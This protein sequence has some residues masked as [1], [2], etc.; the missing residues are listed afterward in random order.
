MFLQ[1]LF[2]CIKLMGHNI[3]GGSSTPVPWT[4]PA[5]NSP[6]LSSRLSRGTNSTGKTQQFWVSALCCCS[7]SLWS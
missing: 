5:L 6:V 2:L 7:S 1:Q 3:T 4:S